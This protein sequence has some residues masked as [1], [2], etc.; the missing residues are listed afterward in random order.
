MSD[1]L[2]AWVLAKPAPQRPAQPDV[3]LP[4]IMSL[5]RHLARRYV[6]RIAPGVSTT[7]VL[8]LARQWHDQGAAHSA[9]DVAL[10]IVLATAAAG[11]G[12]VNA[13][14]RHGG[15]DMLTTSAF[16][17]AG[18]FAV[19]AVAAYA[20][21]W[22]LPLIMWA[23]STLTVYAISAHFWRQDRRAAAERDHQLTR[24]T[25]RATTEV[26]ATFIRAA[27]DVEQVRVAAEV[28]AARVQALEE[29]WKHRLALNDAPGFRRLEMPERPQLVRL[30]LPHPTTKED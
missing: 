27:A 14:G 24:E 10:M 26:Q 16:A 2:P 5:G 18:A 11:F 25:L 19:T 9:G 7:V 21:G 8:W 29:A 6:A 30:T 1:Q 13:T 17:A 23:L 20:N 12:I 3:E 22:A 28:E 4:Q 15:E